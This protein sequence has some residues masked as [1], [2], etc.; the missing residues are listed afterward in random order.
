MDLMKM[1]ANPNYLGSWDLDELPNRE[2]VLTIKSFR[3][4]KVV[5]G[6]KNDTCTVCYFEQPVKPMI[7]NIT[8]KKTLCKLYKTKDTEKLTG[9]NVLIGVD[10][11][12]AFGDVF[13]ALRIR[14]KIPTAPTGPAP[15]C[16]ECGKEIAPASGMTADQVAA[17]TAK[18]YGVKL[19]AKC[20]ASRKEQADG[21]NA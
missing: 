2:I 19:C 20:A 16:S 6:G 10:S 13:D 11:V 18:K 5:N 1:G 7:L 12:S 3:D 17:Y 21:G 4:E 14:R 9:K 8:N 15:V